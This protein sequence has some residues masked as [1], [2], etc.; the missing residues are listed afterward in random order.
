[1]KLIAGIGTTVLFLLLGVAGLAGTQQEQQQKQEHRAKPEKQQ[2]NL[3]KAVT[4]L[5]K[6]YP[7]KVKA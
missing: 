5:L 3:T 7:P 4:K 6:N 1:M 2:K